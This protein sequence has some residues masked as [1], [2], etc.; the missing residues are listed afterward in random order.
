MSQVILGLRNA[1]AQKDSIILYI[2]YLLSLLFGYF[3]FANLKSAL[4]SFSYN[5]LSYV[6]QVKL[7]L[8]S[9]FDI[10][11]FSEISI[12]ALVVLVSFFGALVVTLLTVY[13]EMRK[14]AIVKSGLYSGFALMLAL[15]GVGCAA[16]GAILLSTLFSI[17][18]L[19]TILVYFPYHGV[20]IGYVGVIILGYL[21]YSLSSKLANPYTC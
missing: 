21:S 5:S 17:F 19:S 6:Q 18:G 3:A 4:A 16:C 7:F 11:Q 20:E 12:L 1:F 13:G 15:L 2:L 8:I 9:F 14:E 10:G